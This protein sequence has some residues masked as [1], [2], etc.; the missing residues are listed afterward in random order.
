MTTNNINTLIVYS[1]EQGISR[2]SGMDINR[3]AWIEI[4]VDYFA[5]Q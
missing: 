2:L 5:E 4:D 1:D 3:R